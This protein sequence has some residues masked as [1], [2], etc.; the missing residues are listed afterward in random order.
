[1]LQ[2]AGTV[3][4][5]TPTTNSLS[6]SHNERQRPVWERS[7]PAFAVTEETFL[8]QGIPRRRRFEAT[9]HVASSGYRRGPGEAAKRVFAGIRELDSPSICGR[10]AGFRLAYDQEYEFE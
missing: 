2:L 5:T 7:Q 4:V 3:S 6:K 8:D 10:S 1:M 9:L